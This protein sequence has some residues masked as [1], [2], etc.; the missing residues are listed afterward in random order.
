MDL[1]PAHSLDDIPEVSDEEEM[2]AARG[3]DVESGYNIIR[4]EHMEGYVSEA[5]SEGGEGLEEGK[6]EVEKGEGLLGESQQEVEEDQQEVEKGEGLLGESQQEVE[7]DQQEVEK[8][9]EFEENRQEVEVKGDE[10]MEERTEQPEPLV[11]AD[12]AREVDTELQ[13]DEEYERARM[14]TPPSD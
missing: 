14:P 13:A 12:S 9:E 3:E 8:G 11:G 1:S 2:G 7:D 10:E 4:R 6:Q 5:S